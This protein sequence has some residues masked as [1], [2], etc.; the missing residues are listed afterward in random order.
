MATGLEDRDREVERHPITF[1]DIW[2]PWRRSVIEQ[3]RFYVDQGKTKLLS[4]FKNIEKEAHEAA[5]RWLERRCEHFDPDQDDSG[6]FEE[7]AYQEGVE[8]HRL[9]SELRD[10][11]RLSI[12]AG[13]YH[14]WDKEL[15]RWL[16][17]EIQHWHRGPCVTEAVW[18]ATFEEILEL[19]VS[20]GLAQAGAG[21]LQKLSACR[22]VVNVYK[23]GEGS[24][25]ERLKTL[26]PEYLR[27]LSGEQS[28]LDALFIDHT[29]LLVTDQQL[30]DFSGAVIEF[31]RKIPN[32]IS[33]NTLNVPAWFAKARDKDL[34]LPTR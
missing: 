9:L 8:Y 7:D 5:E 21:Y 26:H 17:T 28:E 6:S 24:S 11:T 34:K 32:R 15:R 29:S 27:G 19:L 23:H 18:K 12:V 16:V 10:Q 14:S 2:N 31:W 25:L 20:C 33:S 4:Q 13:M 1:F 30:E 22:Y 3:H